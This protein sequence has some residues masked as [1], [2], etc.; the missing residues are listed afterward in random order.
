MLL[1]VPSTAL[2]QESA[3]PEREAVERTKDESTSALAV[4]AELLGMQRRE[5]A[6][7]LAEGHPLA[8]I[9]SAN[10][11]SGPAL[12]DALLESTEARL[13]EAVRSGRLTQAEADHKENVARAR[14]VRMVEHSRKGGP[15][16]RRSPTEKVRQHGF[17]VGS[18][19]K[20]LGTTSNELTSRLDQGQSFATIATDYGMTREALLAALSAPVGERLAKATAAGEINATNAQQRLASFREKLALVVDRSRLSKH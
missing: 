2:A 5:L 10:G 20:V 11:S 8:D 7:L 16:M 1:T 4:A 14:F 6:L 9:A 13:A 3:K 15:A 18:V 17:M 19:A 12:V